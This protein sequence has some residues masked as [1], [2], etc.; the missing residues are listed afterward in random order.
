MGLFDDLLPS[1]SSTDEPAFKE[2]YA[3]RSSKLGINPNPDDPQHFYDYRAAF[4]SGAEPDSSGHWPSQFKQPGHPREILDGV[5]TRT[6]EKVNGRIG[7]FDDLI[8]KETKKTGPDLMT[9]L[10]G[11]ADK[12]PL[13]RAKQFALGAARPIQSV[14]PPVALYRLYLMKHAKDELAK[15]NPEPAKKWLSAQ[16]AERKAVEEFPAARGAGGF[17]GATAPFLAG[18]VTTEA[19]LGKELARKIASLPL[20]QRALVEGLKFSP[21]AGILGA[22]ERGQQAFTEGAPTTGKDIIKAGA[23]SAAAAVPFG[24]A[25]EVLAT[26]GRAL[27]RKAF[28]ST[29]KVIEDEFRKQNPKIKPEIFDDFKAFIRKAAAYEGIDPQ[30]GPGLIKSF[31]IR[32]RMARRFGEGVDLR[33]PGGQAEPPPEPAKLAPRGPINPVR[34]EPAQEPP[35]LAPRTPQVEPPPMA[36]PSP[37]LAPD[38]KASQPVQETPAVPGVVRAQAAP[39]HFFASQASAEKAIEYVKSV[40]PQF[41]YEIVKTPKGYEV[42]SFVKSTAGTVIPGMGTMP[43]AEAPVAGIPEVPAAVPGIPEVPAAP[44]KAPVQFKGKA[45]RA[46][47]GFTQERGTTAADVIRHEQEAGNEDIQVSVE[48]M[49]ELEKLPAGRVIWV[50]KTKK[51]ALRY[52]NEV[53]EEEI[54]K[55]A[56]ILAEDGDGGFLVLKP[57][58]GPGQSAKAPVSG[59]VPQPP[60]VPVSAEQQRIAAGTKRVGDTASEGLIKSVTV[61]TRQVQELKALGARMGFDV[62]TTPVGKRQVKVDYFKKKPALPIAEEPEA[63]AAKETLTPEQKDRIITALGGPNAKTKYGTVGNLS[64]KDLFRLIENRVKR[65]ESKKQVS[66]PKTWNARVLRRGGLDPEKLSKDHNLQDFKESGGLSTLRVGGGTLDE[67]AASFQNEGLL[68]VPEGK[69]PGD[70]L[71]ELLTD[72]KLRII[73]SEQDVESQMEREA[74]EYYKEKARAEKAGISGADIE[75][76]TRVGQKAGEIEGKAAIAE[77]FPEEVGDAFEP[78]PPV[79]PEPPSDVQTEIPGTEAQLPDRPIPP[80]DLI[81]E[82]PGGLFKDQPDTLYQADYSVPDHVLDATFAK[83]AEDAWNGKTQI[84]RPIPVS[85]SPRVLEMLGAKSLPVTISSSKISDIR[86]EHDAIPFEAIASLPN[87][88]RDPLMVFDSVTTPGSFV[89]VSDMK[90]GDEVVLA[91]VHLSVKEGRQYVNRVASV[92]GKDIGIMQDWIDQKK[93]RYVDDKR[94]KGGLLSIGLQLPKEGVLGPSPK[95]RILTK[96]DLVK[97]QSSQ[98]GAGE[99]STFKAEK[100]KLKLL[101]NRHGVKD[102]VIRMV[103]EIKMPGGRLAAGSTQDGTVVSM[104]PK[105]QETTGYHEAFHV[106]VKR[107]GIVDLFKAA[108]D[109]VVASGQAK[110]G[111]EAEE[112]LAEQF[113][114]YAPDP[115]GQTFGQATRRFFEKILDYLRSLLGKGSKSRQLFRDLLNPKKKAGPARTFGRER[116]ETKKTQVDSPEFKR[117]FGESKVVDAQGQPLVVYHGTDG[118]FN[119]FKKSKYGSNGPGIYFT[120]ERS[121]AEAH[122]KRVIEAYVKIEGP[123]DGIIAGHEIIVKKPEN[124]KAANGNRGTFDPKNPDIRFQ[125]ES[126]LAKSLRQSDLAQAERR[127]AQELLE[128]AKVIQETG[129]SLFES[130]KSEG[131]HSAEDLNKMMLSI[132][133]LKK[134]TLK[135]FLPEAKKIVEQQAQELAK[136]EVLSKPQIKNVRASIRKIGR[137]LRRQQS[138]ELSKA[139]AVLNAA[140]VGNL[141]P[142]QLMAYSKAFLGKKSG[143]RISG[144]EVAAVAAAMTKTKV[145]RITGEFKQESR[146]VPKQPQISGAPPRI[147]RSRALT[148]IGPEPKRD[149]GIM[150]TLPTSE[151]DPMRQAEIL[152]GEPGGYWY[153]TLVEPVANA[154]DKA[155]SES[156]V[157][158]APIK[159]AAGNI[160]P[161]SKESARVQDLAER[162]VSIEQATDQEKKLE[163]EGRKTYDTFISSNNEALT[164]LGRPTIK[165]LKNYATHFIDMSFFDSLFGGLEN[166]PP[167]ASKGNYS[168]NPQVGTPYFVY[169]RMGAKY[170]RDYLGGLARYIQSSMRLQHVGR[171]VKVASA[172][173]EKLA[174]GYKANPVGYPNA[175]KYFTQFL[176]DAAGKPARLDAAWGVPKKLQDIL[177]L[178]QHQ[179]NKGMILGNISTALK[180]FQSTGGGIAENGLFWQLRGQLRMVQ[181]ESWKFVLTHSPEMRNRVRFGTLLDKQ[182]AFSRKANFFLEFNDQYQFSSSWMARFEQEIKGGTSFEQAVRLAEISAI[183]TNATMRKALKSPLMRQRILGWATQLQTFVVNQRQQYFTDP[184]LR[185]RNRG[186]MSGWWQLAVLI[187]LN[188][189]L[190]KLYDK[191]T[192]RATTDWTDFVPFPLSTVVKAVDSD[193][194]FVPTAI[195]PF[196]LL[197]EAIVGYKRGENLDPIFADVVRAVMMYIPGGNQMYKTGTGALAL[198]KGGVFTPTGKLRFPLYGPGDAFQALTQG[199][200]ATRSAREWRERGFTPESYGSIDERIRTSR[201]PGERQ[202]LRRL[203]RQQEKNNQR[204]AD[205][206]ADKKER[207]SRFE[208]LPAR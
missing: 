87:T 5:N 67:L 203:Y 103:D 110:D 153:R 55:G 60:A 28:Q 69:D 84:D 16:E 64:D 173:I 150:S 22:S 123:Q 162:N 151:I 132:G 65:P 165:P 204:L 125:E 71:Y 202:H 167:E 166:V 148:T 80:K 120:T 177:D 48:L 72:K 41:D 93:L 138:S 124:I 180:Q 57:P 33:V 3:D 97:Y 118:D 178:I 198:D 89:V 43:A 194:R 195:K 200:S 62:K 23:V 94:A 40:A 126:N 143:E 113:A 31:L 34:V 161:R 168:M 145:D 101:F 82:E 176:S 36:T 46:E 11:E 171:A 114:K 182:G 92:Y 1:K 127:V 75:S 32:K 192:G 26:G 107:E 25:G 24:A 81:Q 50:T 9:R 39:P 109:E 30:E 91:A 206:R 90:I 136:A 181:P 175:Y 19:M 68:V 190:N 63:P 51:E 108:Q 152:D 4:R 100:A 78:A 29:L 106:L 205:E 20:A 121:L 201:D 54:G 13:E 79:E 197:T 158:W 58:P 135:E 174:P 42:Q 116:F 140:H 56:Q 10:A 156:E 179:T 21:T 164:A 183:K 142:S 47:T 144:K 139:T 157:W 141:T 7:L 53:S 146:F 86:K 59:E 8:P 129:K 74:V 18:G 27:N 88:L 105:P 38:L 37:P 45:F 49:K 122:G 6:G 14:L 61:P 169:Q 44:P 115:Q 147:P 70:Y 188:V 184:V 149:V 83:V 186:A 17:A 154:Y 131:G 98:R 117:W 196:V 102:I 133:S 199:P 12:P 128:K 95:Q 172:E 185:G 155:D 163:A 15:G 130:M 137:Q 73:H 76:R 77:E 189:A 112:I 111:A 208:N 99:R 207:K 170:T 187:G 134:L 85:R 160:K 159:K 96:D 193:G 191:L 52:G 35:V 2:W 104:V 66:E 119:V